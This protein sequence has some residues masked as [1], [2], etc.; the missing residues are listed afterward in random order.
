ME[1]SKG[2]DLVPLLLKPEGVGGQLL[3]LVLED[4]V[5]EVLELKIIEYLSS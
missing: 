4:V 1:G 2:L 3:L 5:L